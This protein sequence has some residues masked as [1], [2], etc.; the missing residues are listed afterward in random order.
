MKLSISG[1]TKK[2]MGKFLPICNARS[3]LPILSNIL[4]LAEGNNLTVLASNLEVVVKQRFDANITEPGTITVSGKKFIDIVDRLT[5]DPINIVSTEHSISIEQGNSKFKMPTLSADDF[6]AFAEFPGQEITLET[7]KLL[8]A[9]KKVSYAVSTDSSR[10]NLNCMLIEGN[11]F[12]AT[13]GH[14]LAKNSNEFTIDTKILMPLV[15]CQAILKCFG[16]NDTCK[17]LVGEKFFTVESGDITLICRLADGDFPDYTRVIPAE[18]GTVAVANTSELSQI[19]KRVSPMA[20]QTDMGVTV[21]V[22]DNKLSISKESSLGSAEDC[23]DVVCS[24]NFEFIVNAK[25]LAECI[26]NINDINT[27]V[28]FIK[29]GAPV[30][31]TPEGD[32]N[33]MSLVMPMRK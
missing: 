19:L 15:S 16:S 10:F 25:Y 24:G 3:P 12:V 27:L 14:R 29:E 31:L 9:V 2:D 6:P 7:G 28:T 32:G 13:D 18:S 4:L 20:I 11:L 23:M 26:S 5:S 33:F 17:L 30:L 1:L 21:S 22:N 8:D